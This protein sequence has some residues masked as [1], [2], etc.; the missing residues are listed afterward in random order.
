MKYFVCENCGNIVEFVNESG[1]PVM[2]CGRKMTEL[3][4]GTSDGAQEKHVPVVTISGDK[5]P[6]EI[7]AVEHPMVEEHYIQWI[8]IETT[9]GSQRV[10]LSPAD[11]P[12]A[13]FCLAAGEEF[14]AAYE[15]CNIHGLW[16]KNNK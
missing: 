10:K 12:R 4:P 7:G 5:V 11:K 14:V 15:Y 2:C 6:V 16:K 9:R 13:E 1:V 8:A 3:V